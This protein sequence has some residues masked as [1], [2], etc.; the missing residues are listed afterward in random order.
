MQN[1]TALQKLLDWIEDE[2]LYIPQSNSNDGEEA[3]DLPY[4]DCEELINKVN[5]F[6]QIERQQIECAYRE[7][8]FYSQQRGQKTTG[9]HDE[10]AASDYYAQ[11][12]GQVEPAERIRNSKK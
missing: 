5:E 9:G 8:I 10:R 12:Y 7:G 6:V 2:T 4:I 11:K 1:Q 3:P